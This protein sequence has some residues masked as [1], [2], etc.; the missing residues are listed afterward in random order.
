MAAKCATIECGF[1]KGGQ[2]TFLDG[3]LA[4]PV[5]TPSGLEQERGISIAIDFD[6][7]EEL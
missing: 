2:T 3:A 6:P 1:R 4:V 5:G 7:N